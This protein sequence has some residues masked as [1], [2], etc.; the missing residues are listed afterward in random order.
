MAKDLMSWAAEQPDWVKDSLRRIAVATNYSVEQADADCILDNVRAA[1]RGSSSAHTLTAID[2]SHL[3]NGSGETRRTVLA[4]LGPVQNIDRLAGGQKLRMAAVGITL[5]YGENGSGKS[6]YIRIAKRLCRSLTADQLRGNVF[7]ASR[8]PMRVQVRYQVGDDAV[9]DIEWDPGTPAPPQLR[10]ISV[11][12]SHNARLYV[13][14]ENRIA[15]LPSELAILEHHG[16]LCQR[17]AVRFSADE[18]VLMPRLRVP[19]PAGYIPGS[20]VSL[21]LAKL[22]PK[23]PSLPSADDLRNMSELSDEELTVLARL[24]TE[25]AA[26]PVALAATRRRAAAVLKRV[27][28]VLGSLRD[29][30]SE[31][32]G[33]TIAS[34]LRELVQAVEAERIA[35]STSFADEP[36]ANVGSTAWRI[37]FEAARDF[38]AAGAELT[39][40]RLPD[41]TGDLCLLCLEPLSPPGAARLARF[42]DFVSGEATKRADGARNALKVL[43]AQVEQAKVPELAVVEESLAG[44]G[45]LDATRAAT[46]AEIIKILGE[47]ESRRSTLL[48]ERAIPTSIPDVAALTST[49]TAE[50]ARLE[51]EAALLQRSASHTEALD[52]MRVRL[53]EL[54]DRVKLANDLETVLQRL[55][56]VVEQR[57]LIGCQAQVATRSISMQ[58]TALRKQLVT[59]ELERRIAEEIG[60]LDLTHL[61]FKVSDSSSG[62]KSL[63][64]VG[65][66]GAS[67]V[68]NNQ[69][70]SE[71]EQRALALACFLAEIGGDD[72]RYGIIVDDPVSSLDHL[73]IRKVAQRLVAEAKKGRQVI[74]FTHNLVFFNEVVS[75][76][77]RAGAAAPLIKTVVAKTQSEGFGVI[78]EN[79]EPWVA[80]LNARIETLRNRAK[81]LKSVKDFDTDQYRRQTKDFYSDLR[82]SWER[83]VEEVVLAKTVVRFVP[84]VMTGRLKEVTVTDED[85]RTIFFAMKRASER[86]G[87]DMSAGR[88]I[89]QPSPDE[90]E[91]DLKVLEDFKIELGRRRKVTS[92]TRSALENPV[93]APLL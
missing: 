18:K 80:D 73:R 61:P 26:D 22:D 8:G 39:P 37:L 33:N 14:S 10:Q 7:D 13:D 60:S 44:Y 90:M 55:R 57:S 4:Q 36:V 27:C 45:Q 92:A 5:V 88:D 25:L 48:E 51:E 83:A 69:V 49:V 62:G 70:L 85:Y 24:E 59:E 74:I 19:L 29:A 11:F 58:I 21:M 30:L 31:T 3:G 82:E 67:T 79:S 42:N 72:A 20:A 6:G 87:H 16:E 71:G 63:F 84:D 38:A 68:R 9:T 54:K 65:L 47:F 43:R 86:S 56:D 46:V 15:Y 78:R 75:E 40:E 64:S 32:V 17:M 34:A 23:A 81:E 50:L 93:G 41:A 76:A 77:A 12:D 1:A 28:E 2:A 53:A 89:P 66:Q 35:A 52:S 91:T